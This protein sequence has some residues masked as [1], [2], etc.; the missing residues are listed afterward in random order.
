MPRVLS[1]L[2]ASVSAQTVHHRTGAPTGYVEHLRQK[3]LDT[4]GVDA[5]VQACY[6]GN[7]LSDGG[8]VLAGTHAIQNS[9]FVLIEPNVE[10][11][12]RGRDATNEEVRTVI[13]TAC[14]KGA[15]P[16]MLMLP[17]SG[18]HRPAASP[19]HGRLTAIATRFGIPVINLRLPDSFDDA[20]MRIQPHT[21]VRGGAWYA[22]RLAPR[23]AAVI[24]DYDSGRLTF[25]PTALV[26]QIRAATATF[27]PDRIYRRLSLS[28][29]GTPGKPVTI[30]Q[31]QTI[32]PHSPV[33]D[34]QTSLGRQSVSL[35]DPYCHFVR[36]SY[37]TLYSGPRPS[38][39][40]IDITCTATDPDYAICRR[41]EQVWPAAADRYL[42]ANG[43]IFA[44]GPGLTSI[45]VLSIDGAR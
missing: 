2:G 6:P 36:Q 31:L 41:D 15:K 4:L 12:S 38:D 10:D 27:P 14:A 23:I 42:H 44:H 24:Q 35:W 30:I 18:V 11:R 25:D 32:G 39:G 8:M 16:I 37:V 45:E 33:I 28:C 17:D 3:H 20:S 29:T 40:R 7:R 22:R 13:A 34:I 5:I 1:V 21:T 43:E 26:T 9:D 19:V